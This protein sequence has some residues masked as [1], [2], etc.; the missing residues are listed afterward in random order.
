MVPQKYGIVGPDVSNIGLV[1]PSVN[2]N[3]PANRHYRHIKDLVQDTLHNANAIMNSMGQGEERKQFAALYPEIYAQ[4][5]KAYEAMLANLSA[6]VDRVLPGHTQ[7]E[8]AIL[9]NNL[10][11]HTGFSAKKDP[12]PTSFSGIG[13][14]L[15]PDMAGGAAGQMALSPQSPSPSIG[16][17]TSSP[18]ASVPFGGTDVNN[19]LGANAVARAANMSGAAES[20]RGIVDNLT[21]YL[22]NGLGGFTA[23]NFR[24]SMTNLGNS[25]GDLVPPGVGD[26]WSAIKNKPYD[27]DMDPPGKL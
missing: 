12:T 8:K 11:G 9:Y 7:E 21:H 10:L 19:L 23:D 4:R 15:S 16:P 14:P 1:G 22:M 18:G 27:Y 26:A 6:D 2:T 3:A 17:L 24:Q 13:G 5:V 20:A 25:M